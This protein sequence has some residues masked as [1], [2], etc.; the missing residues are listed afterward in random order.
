MTRANLEIQG[1]SCDHCIRAV[2]HALAA[3]PGVA[4]ESVRLGRA[5]VRYDETK[6]TPDLL[7][8]AVTDAGY[9]ATL[10]DAGN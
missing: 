6:I 7:T 9:S 1:M 3:L 8:A 5:D 2:N 10:S 4:V